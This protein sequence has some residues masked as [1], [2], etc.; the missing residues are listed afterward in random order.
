MLEPP[1][2]E[3]AA[4]ALERAWAITRRNARGPIEQAQALLAWLDR[5]RV[6][7]RSP[8]WDLL[9]GGEVL[10]ETPVAISSCDELATM[11]WFAHHDLAIACDTECHL[12]LVPQ[13]AFETMPE[14][15]LDGAGADGATPYEH[16]I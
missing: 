5:H 7:H 14:V 13:A 6:D 9:D 12:F 11:R 4:Q 1:T 15:E 3:K 8:L 10:N 2:I 16:L